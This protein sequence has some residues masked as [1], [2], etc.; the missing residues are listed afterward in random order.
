M[1]LTNPLTLS[2]M[3]LA[4][5]PLKSVARKDRGGKS[6]PQWG[7]EM[8]FAAAPQQTSSPTGERVAWTFRS[9]PGEGALNCVQE[10]RSTKVKGT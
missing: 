3:R 10:K 2:A 6:S 1:R 8:G 4:H 7:E 5:A 9:K